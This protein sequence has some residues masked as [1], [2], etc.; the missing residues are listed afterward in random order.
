MAFFVKTL[1][2]FCNSDL[3]KQTKL[4]LEKEI[5]KENQSEPGVYKKIAEFVSN[6]SWSFSISFHTWK[7]QQLIRQNSDFFAKFFN[8]TDKTGNVCFQQISDVMFLVL[9]VHWHWQAAQAGVSTP[10]KLTLDE[11]IKRINKISKNTLQDLL[12]LGYSKEFII[13]CLITEGNLEAVA[14]YPSK[15]TNNESMALALLDQMDYQ[16]SNPKKKALI[17]QADYDHNNAF[18]PERAIYLFETFKS[19]FNTRF[20]IIKTIDVFREEISKAVQDQPQVIFIRAHGRPDKFILSYKEFFTSNSIIPELKEL[21]PH[22]VIVLSCCV[23]G[24]GKDQR[25]NVANQICLL[26]P[27]TRVFAPTDV[28]CGCDLRTDENIE[29]IFVTPKNAQVKPVPNHLL[30]AEMA[31]NFEPNSYSP[32]S[33]TIVKTKDRLQQI[34]F[35]NVA[36]SI[37]NFCGDWS[38]FFRYST[39]GKVVV[40][41]FVYCILLQQIFTRI[42]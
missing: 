6:N 21:A 19:N 10:K 16:T 3:S 33:Q 13:K 39:T 23:V 35:Q 17:L 22:T 5:L 38:D 18:C 42:I 27:Q 31:S 11:T 2:F 1:S 32:N 34:S 14:K 20:R 36:N 7:N 37:C 15:L 30:T 24:K 41:L 25:W 4:D 9:T 8:L 26:A 28:C 29:P 40:V 12:T